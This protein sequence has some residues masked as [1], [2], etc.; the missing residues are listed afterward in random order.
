[1]ATNEQQW[2]EYEKWLAAFA[3]ARTDD[4]HTKLKRKMEP[5]CGHWIDSGE[6]YR[7][8]VWKLNADT[9]ITQRYDCEF[10]ARGDLREG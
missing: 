5:G 6:P 1:M 7:Y 10:C 9:V 3:F 4:R 8:Q 2:Q